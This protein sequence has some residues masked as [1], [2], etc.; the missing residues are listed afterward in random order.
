MDEF[1]LESFSEDPDRWFEDNGY[2]FVAGYSTG[3]T[4]SSVLTFSSDNKQV[5][6]EVENKVGVAFG[7]SGFGVSFSSDYKKISNITEGKS[8][9]KTHINATGTDN[10]V[11]DV[12]EVEKAHSMF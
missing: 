2:F 4:F 12:E 3:S 7:G 6:K 10:N 11:N 8:D 5:R 9:F 1:E